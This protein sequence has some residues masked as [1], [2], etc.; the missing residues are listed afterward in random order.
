MN[1]LTQRLRH[2]VSGAI[3][4]GEAEPVRAM[5]F[6]TLDEFRATG[7][8]V[9]NLE[10]FNECDQGPGRVYA[11][12]CT[13]ALDVEGWCCT[14][15]NDSRMGTLADMEAFLFDWARDARDLYVAQE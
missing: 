13:I 8:D 5:R 15:S 7:R 2:H 14:I 1:K 4:R 3:A 10:E 6:M 9:A 11:G 12:D